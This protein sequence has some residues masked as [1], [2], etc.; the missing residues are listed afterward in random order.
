MCRIRKKGEEMKSKGYLH[1]LKAAFSFFII[2]TV[3]YYAPSALSYPV[4]FEDAHLQEITISKRPS[5]VVSLVPSITEIIFSIGASDALK[6]ITYHITCPP[7]TTQKEIVGGFFSPSLTA[8]EEVQP[9]VIFLHG[10]HGKVRKRFKGEGC[11]LINLETNSIT[12]IYKNIHLLGRIFHREEQAA[13]VAVDIKKQ[14]ELITKKVERIPESK[15]KRVVRIMGYDPVM[16]PGDDSFQN[17]MISAAGGIPPELDK[18]GHIVTMTK[19]EWMNFNPQIIYGCGGERE[20]AGKFLNQPGWRDVDAV[21]NGKIFYFPCDL[22]CRASTNTGYFVSWLSAR[23]YTE[24]FSK[25]E[26]QVL[27]ERVF[28]SRPLSVPL[29]YIESARIVYSHIHDFVHKT[30]IIDFKEPLSVVST[31]EGPRNGIDSVGNHYSPPPCWSL[32]HEQ[33]VRGLEAI[34]ER[35]YEVLGKST[36]TASF[37]FTGADMDNVAIKSRRFR[38]MEVFVLATAGVRGNAVRMSRDQGLYYDPGTIN[39]IILSNMRLTPRAMTRAIISATEA[40]TAALQDLDIRSTYSNRVHQATGTGTDNIIVVSGRG[41]PIDATGGHTKM[42]E[43][44]AKAVYDAVQSAVNKQNGLYIRRNVFQRCEERNINIFQLAGHVNADHALK[45]Q[46][47]H[48]LESLLLDPEYASFIN[49]S[50][51][52]SDDYEKGLIS[53]LSSFDSWCR[54]IAEEIAGKSIEFTDDLIGDS[55]LPVVIYKTFNTLV[56]GIQYRDKG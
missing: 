56:N 8:I 35:K 51:A 55:D 15:R 48:E 29:N 20:A 1:A 42:G 3:F 34:R 49:A 45:R 9:D 18:K 40:K 17:E 47:F 41:K 46:I 27:E 16:V 32:E 11:L 14:L 13:G 19:D 44:I 33:M 54:E 24:E 5:R 26:N 7:E 4:K 23:V 21:K 31:L 30:L 25:K 38:D 2:L 50:F 39:I 53:D 43:L 36:E 10:I 6:G 28:K 12:D 22:T 52:I 37:L